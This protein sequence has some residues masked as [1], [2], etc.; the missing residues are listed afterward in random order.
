MFEC[1]DVVSVCVCIEYKLSPIIALIHA[2]AIVVALGRRRGQMWICFLEISE[3][4]VSFSI[5]SIIKK[6]MP[7]TKFKK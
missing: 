2:L 4:H 7:I 1:V 5:C 3:D 6:L